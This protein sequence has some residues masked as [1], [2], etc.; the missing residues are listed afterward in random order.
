MKGSSWASVS[1]GRQTSTETRIFTALDLRGST[2]N[3]VSPR[4]VIFLAFI[5]RWIQRRD[6]LLPDKMTLRGSRPQSIKTVTEMDSTD[7]T[8]R[9]SS[10]WQDDIEGSRPQS[11][12]IW[13][14]LETYVERQGCIKSQLSPPPPPKTVGR[15]NLN[16]NP[17]KHREGGLF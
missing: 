12:K 10:T 4:W 5:L 6:V 15:S 17:I 7:S 11:I 3:A 13:G 2:F 9:C 16:F 14:I 8:A 1:R